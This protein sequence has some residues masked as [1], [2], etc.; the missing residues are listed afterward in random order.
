MAAQGPLEIIP[1]RHR[2]V[3]QVLPALR[4]LMEPGATLS[5]QGTQLFVRAS[6]A[7]V[8]EIRRALDEIDRPLRRLQVSVRFDD[9]L[10]SAAQGVET[11]GRITNRGS[12]VDVRVQDRQSAGAERVDQ[13]VQVLEGGRAFIST[14]RSTPIYDGSVFRETASGFDAIPRLAG[15]GVLVEIAQRRETLARD[16]ALSTTVSGRLGEWLEIGGALEAASRDDQAILSARASRSSRS[17]RVWLKVDE[18]RP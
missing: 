1:L 16:Q 2:T 18:V 7:N 4:P 8:A 5:G 6:P 13:R 12:S 17:G 14:G 3:D 15:G 11:S 10:D 9:A